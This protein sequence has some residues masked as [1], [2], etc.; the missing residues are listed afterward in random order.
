MHDPEGE[1][2]L[3]RR[4]QRGARDFD[5]TCV[6]TDGL[7]PVWGLGD[8]ARNWWSSDSSN[9]NDRHTDS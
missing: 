9:R 4:Q 3:A 6:V 7:K 2:T 8:G 1:G 5:D